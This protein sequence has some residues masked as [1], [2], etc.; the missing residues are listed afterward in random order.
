MTAYHSN[1]LNHLGLVAGMCS[2]LGLVDAINELLPSNSPDQIVSNGHCVLAMILNGLGF[3]NKRLYLT[4]HFFENKPLSRLLGENIEAAHLNDDRLGRC[5]DALHNYG[6]ETLYSLLIPKF[7]KKLGLVCSRGHM[8]ITS[9]EVSGAYA[10]QSDKAISIKRGYSKSH[11]PDLKQVGLLLICSQASRLPVLMRPLAGNQEETGAY[12]QTISDHIQQLRSDIGLHYLLFDSKGY[13]KKNLTALSEQAGLYWICRVPSTLT[14]SQDL[15]AKTTLSDM[16]KLDDNYSYVMHTY[17]YGTVKQRWLLLHSAQLA[18]QRQA[19]I[20]R[21]INKELDN[22]TKAFTKLGKRS[23]NCMED[24]QQALTAFEKELQNCRLDKSHIRPKRKYLRAGKPTSKTPFKMTYYIEGQVVI[25]DD[26]K[27]AKLDK[28]GFFILATN[29]L[30]EKVLS[31]TGILTEY[32]GQ[33]NVE[34]GF[35]FL[36]DPNVVASALFF[37]KNERIEALL[38]I[39]TLC[40]FV[41]AALEYKIRQQL[42]AHPPFFPNQKGKPTI[43]PT[44]KWV[45]QYFVGIHVLY[46]EMTQ[47]QLVLN[48]KEQHRKLLDILGNNYACYYT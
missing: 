5:L 35:R 21:K 25:D 8:D 39:M 30:D 15:Y 40:L 31:D 6:V 41:Y 12:Q 10:K 22:K 42:K 4:P 36:K 23:F 16:T 17:T 11:R 38:M 3:V 9:F 46:I 34:K 14:Y 37:K 27:Q 48:L 2:E 13:T 24:A 33:D 19:S 45:F 18:K 44:A 7:V 47:Q 20:T 26:I 1:I 32:K 29:Q 28:A 43:K